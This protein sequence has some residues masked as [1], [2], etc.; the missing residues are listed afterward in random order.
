MP[1]LLETAVAPTSAQFRRDVLNGLRAGWKS[2]PCKYFYDER[3]SRIFDEIC[4]LPEYYPTRTESAIMQEQG[5]EMGRALGPGVVLVE[6]GSGSSLKTRILLSHLENAAAYVP[7]DISGEHL[8]RSAQNLAAQFPALPVLPLCADYTRPF[9][10]PE[11]AGAPKAVYFPGSTI[12]NFAPDEAALF[13]RGIA[14][15]VGP[16]G[17]VLI[18]VDLAKSAAILEPAYNDSQG[19][20]AAFNLNLLE[21]INRE[22][23]GDFDLEL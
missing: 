12:G 13:L 2:L 1:L 15:V 8:R 17:A 6:Y 19:V 4:R 14:E 5:A 20:T 10:L 7:L 9:H 3:G 18:G 21:R 11:I 16:G 22:L 23:D